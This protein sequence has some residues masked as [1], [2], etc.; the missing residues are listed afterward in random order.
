MDL[1]APVST[2]MSRQVVVANQFH[3]FSQVL[4]LFSEHGM[5]HLPI[6]DGHE[7]VIGIIS[8]N[9]VMKLLTNPKYKDVGINLDSIDEMINI[10]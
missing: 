6:V 1:T 5:H 10:L 9:D 7:T 2:I 8:S 4:Q 3:N